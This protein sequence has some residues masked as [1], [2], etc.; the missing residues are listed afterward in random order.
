MKLEHIHE[1][2]NTVCEYSKT[3]ITQVFCKG[4]VDWIRVQYVSS[5]G[6]LKLTYLQEQRVKYY[7]SVAEAAKVILKETQSNIST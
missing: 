5:S 2:L 3:N 6:T 4:E 7:E 1:L